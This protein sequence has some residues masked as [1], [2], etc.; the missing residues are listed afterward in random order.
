MIFT[1]MRE[2]LETMK[3]EGLTGVATLHRGIGTQEYTFKDGELVDTPQEP[4]R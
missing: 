4:Q 1:T 3:R 2:M